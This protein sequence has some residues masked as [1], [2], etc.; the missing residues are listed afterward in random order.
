ML[1]RSDKSTESMTAAVFTITIL[2]SATTYGLPAATL[3]ATVTGVGG[4]DA[5][6][7][8]TLM[9]TI[10]NDLGDRVAGS[11][12]EP[13]LNGVAA[14]TLSMPTLAPG[15]YSIHARYTPASSR[16]G[17]SIQE[18]SGTL[19][20][21]AATTTKSIS[22]SANPATGNLTVTFTA[23]VSPQVVG[24]PTGTVSFFKGTT[25]I[26]SGSVKVVNGRTVTSFSTRTLLKGVHEITAMYNGDGNFAASASSP[27]LVQVMKSVPSTSGVDQSLA[28]PNSPRPTRR[29]GAS[30]P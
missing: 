2:N 13:V 16:P 3:K 20:V 30:A 18:T 27:P 11:N 19:V 25:A 12:A 15:A 10:E 22:S 1:F 24:T 8:G 14:A 23:V 26:G 9:F 21:R 28:T 17:A 4:A 5:V 29:A 7:D 6:N